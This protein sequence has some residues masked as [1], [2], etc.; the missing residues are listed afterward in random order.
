M[1]EGEVDETVAVAQSTEEQFG[2]TNTMNDMSATSHFPN[3]GFLTPP[4]LPGL[5]H[6]NSSTEHM[7]ATPG[8]HSL[9]FTNHFGI[10]PTTDIEYDCGPLHED[11]VLNTDS[12]NP[13]IDPSLWDLADPNIALDLSPEPSN[14]GPCSCLSL[15]YL[16]LTE[17]QSVPTFSF[18][19]VIIPLRKAMSALSDL[20]HC[21]QCPKEVFSAIQNLQSVVSLFKAIT[22]RFN[23]VLLEVNAEA[24]R[25]EHEGKKKPYR[26]G[27]NNPAL[28][29][30]HTGTLDC[31]MGFNIELEARDWK[32]IVKTALRT[33]AY[34]GG[35]NP[36]PLMDL[37]KE[38][39]A[40]QERWHSD[41]EMFKED[42]KHF[43]P[44]GEECDRTKSCEALGADHIR[45][46]I[47]CLRWD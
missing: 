4:D 33:E 36:R 45:R 47:D 30:L 37:L 8:A 42:M 18:P 44:A 2:H 21:S 12:I 39:E 7:T 5:D 24:D 31:P 17:L 26:I 41:D 20:I 6:S 27:D 15:T 10:L 29:H 43:R 23:K 32:K 40:R 28:F 1:R 34:G 13:T 25:L 11:V 19:Q 3:F 9:D 38:I 35:S 14:I 16:T 46:A 22:E